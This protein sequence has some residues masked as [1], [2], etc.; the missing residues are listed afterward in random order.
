MTRTPVV[1][2]TATVRPPRPSPVSRLRA[3]VARVARAVR[4]AHS[5]G[6]PF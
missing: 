5:S 6:V 3:F 1:A 4:G 2:P